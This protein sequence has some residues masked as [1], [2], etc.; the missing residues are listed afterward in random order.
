MSKR[1]FTIFLRQMLDHSKEVL[2][3][4]NGKSRKDLD[5]DRLL[6]LGVVRLLEIIGE[7]GARIP[8][9]ERDRYP[10]IPWT[11]I[12]GMRNRLIHGYDKVDLNLVW[13]VA[14]R[15]LPSLIRQLEQILRA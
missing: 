7:S 4:M 8:K 6:N 1:D 15:S 10:D 13:T 14:T 11:D 12:V 3:H 5:E 9:E 2:F